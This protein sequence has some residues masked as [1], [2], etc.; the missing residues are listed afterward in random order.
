MQDSG[1]KFTRLLELVAGWVL[2]IMMLLLLGNVILR[3]GF[4]SGIAASEELARYM[5]VWLIFIGAVV[6]LKRRQH[7]GVDSLVRRLPVLGQVA[8]AVIGELVMLLC[9]GVLVWGSIVQARVN[10]ETRSPVLGIPI[11]LV[12]AAAVLGGVAMSLLLM[13]SLW[14]LLMGHAT[15]ADLRLS[16]DEAEQAHRETGTN[17]QA[18]PALAMS[19]TRK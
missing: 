10:F 15:A 2:G 8:A 6:G 13:V 19:E 16:V 18:S 5:F 17:I 7:L 3:Y 11:S 9:C 12:Y 4:N 1:D 14:R